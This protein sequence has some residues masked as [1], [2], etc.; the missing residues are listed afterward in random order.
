VA[1]PFWPHRQRHRWSPTEDRLVLRDK[2]RSKRPGAR[3]EPRPG[4]LRNPGQRDCANPRDVAQLLDASWLAGSR[5]IL[6]RD[7]GPVNPTV[8]PMSLKLPRPRRCSTM[9]KWLCSWSPTTRPTSQGPPLAPL[10]GAPL[11]ASECGSPKTS[12]PRLFPTR[13]EL[14]PRMTSNE[15]SADR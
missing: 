10:T 15:W 2:G 5:P 13:I 9:P 6:R 1:A 3:L 14:A 11:H 8:S 7:C 4:P 12:T